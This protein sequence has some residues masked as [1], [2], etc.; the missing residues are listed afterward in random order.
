[1]LFLIKLY[2]FNFIILYSYFKNLFSN[3]FRI[4]YNIIDIY[5]DSFNEKMIDSHNQCLCNKYFHSKKTHIK[6]QKINSMNLYLLNHFEKINKVKNPVNNV[7]SK[8]PKT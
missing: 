3:N 5:R 4:F 7:Y 2:N 1:M 6:T 8:Y